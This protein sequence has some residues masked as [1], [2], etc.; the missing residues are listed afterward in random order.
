MDSLSQTYHWSY[1]DCLRL[2]MPQIFMLSHAASVN[3]ERADRML[4]SKRARKEPLTL[5]ESIAEAPI[6]RGKKFSEL[7]SAEY[8]E[9]QQS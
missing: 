6:W 4:T 7:T 9:Y 5:Q 1:A 3:K 2:T 8:L